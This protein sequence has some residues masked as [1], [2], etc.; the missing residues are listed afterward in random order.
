[1]QPVN[2]G[3]HRGQPA[4]IAD[5][6][7][8]AIALQYIH[9]RRPTRRRHHQHIH[10]WTRD[11]RN[12]ERPLLHRK[13]LAIQPLPI[14]PV[15]RQRLYRRSMNRLLSVA[16]ARPPIPPPALHPPGRARMAGRNRSAKSAAGRH[17]ACMTGGNRS[18][19]SA[20]GRQFAGM[21]GRNRSAKSAAGRQFASM[22]GRNRSA[23]SAAGRQFAS[24]AGLADSAKNAVGQA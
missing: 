9:R 6:E 12:A 19:K 16:S 1:L 15:L 13:P 10:S 22:A 3:D 2:K 23:K 4:C 21:A 24:M 20:A 14:S 11:P 5:S 8:V 18:A 17:F 7:T